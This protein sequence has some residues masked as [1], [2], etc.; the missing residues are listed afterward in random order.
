MHLSIVLDQQ[1]IIVASEV[2]HPRDLLFH[3]L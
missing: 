1:V 3:L 2:E